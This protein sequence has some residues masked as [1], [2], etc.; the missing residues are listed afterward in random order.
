M[1]N[2]NQAKFFHAR[3]T[4]AFK[5]NRNYRIYLRPKE[6]LFLTAGPG[7]GDQVAMHTAIHGGLVGGLVGGLIAKNMQKKTEKRTKELDSANEEGLLALLET[8]KCGF[9]CPAD[10]VLEASL[11]P[12]SVWHQIAYSSPNHVGLLLLNIRD[13]GKVK[14]EFNSNEEMRTAL[15]EL[16]KILGDIFVSK[17]VWD[18]IQE[19]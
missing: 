2:E 1:G 4:Y 10:D 16:P 3:A 12:R 14:L 5:T 18:P 17:V 19:K 11:N 6:L 9:R 13:R 15:E 8:D 7:K